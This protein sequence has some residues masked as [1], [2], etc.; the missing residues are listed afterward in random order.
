[1]ALCERVLTDARVLAGTFLGD[2]FGFL[3]SAPASGFPYNLPFLSNPMYIG[4]T[5]R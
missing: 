2:Y 4:A 1:M 5:M 3:A